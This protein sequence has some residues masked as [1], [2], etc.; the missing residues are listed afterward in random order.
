MF[1]AIAAK[2][3]GGLAAKPI[4]QAADG[5]ISQ[6]I[7]SRHFKKQVAQHISVLGKKHSTIQIYRSGV[8][9]LDKAFVTP[10]VISVDVGRMFLASDE[11]RVISQDKQLVPPNGA[12]SSELQ[13]IYRSNLQRIQFLSSK[14]IESERL[15]FNRDDNVVYLAQPGGGKSTV[16][17]WRVLRELNET[18]PRIP[19]FLDSRDLEKNSVSGYLAVWFQSLGGDV[20]MLSS[21]QGGILLVLD[22]LD[23]LTQLRMK[24]V[25]NELRDVHSTYP[26]IRIVAA[27]RSAA[28]NGELSSFSEYTILP[29]DEDQIRDFI[30]KWF[31][32]RSEDYARDLQSRVLENPR[33]TEISSQPLML[34]LVCNAFE[35]FLDVSVRTSALYDQCVEALFWTW[36][37]DRGIVREP[38]FQNVD[39]EK[40]KW[41]HAY[42]AF[43]IHSRRKRYV[44]ARELREIVSQYAPRLGLSSGQTEKVISGIAS[45][46]GLL[47]RFFEN[48]FGFRHLGLQEYLAARWLSQDMRWVDAFTPDAIRDSWWREVIGLCIGTLSDATIAVEFILDIKGPSE[49]DKLEVI[50]ASLRFDPIL[51]EPLR[52]SILNRTLNIFHNGRKPD[53]DQALRMLIGIDDTWSTPI[54]SYSL[55]ASLPTERDSLRN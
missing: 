11:L 29:F 41:L 40:T 14:S 5:V 30:K 10:N 16:L 15:E 43:Q 54:L 32:G 31:H 21:L 13:A 46:V 22:G 55:S 4:G 35:R 1:E 28:Y 26:S 36:D 27:C 8:Q 50:C 44:E 49:I 23:E 12:S 9:Q 39:I 2:I 24:A 38:L 17:S 48:V 25:C 6:L 7:K 42:L 45:N 33:I 19:I 18:S 53:S 3:I 20:R 37:A 52:R 47:E 34:S 51:D